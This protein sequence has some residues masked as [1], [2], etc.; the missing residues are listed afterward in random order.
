MSD[1]RTPPPI[2][3]GPLTLALDDK[4]LTALNQYRQAYHSWSMNPGFGPKAEQLNHD[5]TEAANV[6]AKA[7]ARLALHATQG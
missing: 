4:A 2:I 3:E 7:T 5:L 1:I 6:L